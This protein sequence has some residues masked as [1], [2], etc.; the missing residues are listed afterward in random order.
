MGMEE[1][2]FSEWVK[3]KTFSTN[4]HWTAKIV[5]AIVAPDLAYP[6]ILGGPFLQSNCILIDHEFGMVTAKA[7][8]FVLVPEPSGTSFTGETTMRRPVPDAD[9]DV[10]R[11]RLFQELHSRTVTRRRDTDEHSTT[12][13]SP[14]HF[15]Q[16]L[17]NRLQV[18]AVWNDLARHEQELRQEFEDRFPSDILHTVRLPDDVL[19]RFRLRDPEKVIK[20]RSYACPK[21]YKDAWRQLL[22]QHL[23]A[24]RIRESSSEYCSP[25]FLIPKADPTVLPRWVNDYRALNANTIPDHYPLP[26][27]E[28][29]LSDCAKGSVWAKI[30]MTNSFFQTR[31][32]P[33]DVK[34]T[35]VMTPFGLYEWVVMPMG[36]RN[37]P[38]TDESGLTEVH[39][40]HLPCIPGRHRDL[41]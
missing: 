34:L 4:R 32:H 10:R 5:R 13:T 41:V 14:G 15:A 19:H 9:T 7:C 3:L 36:C 39:W 27:V 25:A 17:A 23:S 40:A 29:I 1:V 35:A 18:L 30:D 38:A 26:C 20:C 28:M 22:D 37:A 2:V 11:T 21:K 16:A 24:G 6:V 8:G 31:V 33:D 12:T